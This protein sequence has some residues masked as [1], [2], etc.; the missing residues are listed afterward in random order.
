M[1]VGFILIP[2]RGA[3]NVIYIATRAPANRPVN[4]AMLRVLDTANI[5]DIRTKEIINSATKAI[6]APPM[7]GVVTA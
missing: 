3:S 5:T 1:R 7:L 4:R 6:L 2:E